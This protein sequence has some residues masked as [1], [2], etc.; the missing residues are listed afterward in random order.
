MERSGCQGSEELE[1]LA[2]HGS[3]NAL[4]ADCTCEETV[5]YPLSPVF[6]T[7][8]HSLLLEAG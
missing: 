4:Q 7:M 8:Y 5:F 3:P 6:L 1:N 2:S